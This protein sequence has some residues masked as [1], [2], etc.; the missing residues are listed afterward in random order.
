MKCYHKRA[1][2]NFSDL[3]MFFRAWEG[4]VQNHLED[5][6]LELNLIAQR[7]TSNATG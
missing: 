5:A 3:V 6:K 1:M 2:K 7:G 4:I